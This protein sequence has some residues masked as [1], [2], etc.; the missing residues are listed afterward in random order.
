MLSRAYI[1]MRVI[2]NST[3]MNKSYEAKLL[4]RL[5]MTTLSLTARSKAC[6]CIAQFDETLCRLCSWEL[7]FLPTYKGS[8]PPFD[9]TSMHLF[10]G[11]VLLLIALRGARPEAKPMTGYCTYPHSPANRPQGVLAMST[12]NVPGVETCIKYT[13]K[14]H[15]DNRLQEN[16][17]TAGNRGHSG[18]WHPTA[19]IGYSD[20]EHSDT[21]HLVVSVLLDSVSLP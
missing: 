4:A 10:S 15:S 14:G 7:T 11:S 2:Y 9:D 3:T 17:M 6:P 20:F 13:T 18:P 8:F 1:T 16:S 12:Y 19:A 5:T 21:S